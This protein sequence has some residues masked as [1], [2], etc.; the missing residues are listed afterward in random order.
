M[1]LWIDGFDDYGNS[2]GGSA[3]PLNSLLRRWAHCVDVES[4][5]YTATRSLMSTDGPSSS[6]ATTWC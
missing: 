5:Y 2:Y 4:D 1:L 3:Y 6:T